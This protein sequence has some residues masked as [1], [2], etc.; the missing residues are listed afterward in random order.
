MFAVNMFLERAGGHYV[1]HNLVTEFDKDRTIAWLPGQLDDAG[2]HSPGGWW[3]RYDLTPNGAGT[4]VTLTYDWSDT[5]QEFRDQ[6]GV[7]LFESRSSRS[8]SRRWNARCDCPFRAT[9][10]RP[11][12]VDPV[13]RPSSARRARGASW[14]GRT[15]E[16]AFGCAEAAN[17]GEQ[18]LV[19][20]IK[21]C[22]C[23]SLQPH[24]H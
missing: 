15:E 18:A 7:P 2:R 11:H 24:C 16:K 5:P 23:M 21:G 9:G 1:M 4:D 13:G 19:G 14:P 3:W 6:V 12:R 20:M 22:S 17:D 8:R 10:D